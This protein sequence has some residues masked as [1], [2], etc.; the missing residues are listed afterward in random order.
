MYPPRFW[1]MVVLSGAGAGLAGGLLMRLL[2]LIEHLAYR[3]T[4]G[5]FLDGVAAVS[6]GRRVAMLFAAG[7]VAG[8]ASYVLPKLA[9]GTVGLTKAIW[10]RSGQMPV[11]AT[12][13]NSLLSIIIVGMGVSLGREG[14]LKDAGGGI[15]SKLA[16]WFSLPVDQRR[17]LVACAAGGGMAAAYNIPF[18]GALFAVE[19]LM[20]SLSFSLV[21]PAL[22]ASMIATGM[23]W[24]FLPDQPTYVVPVYVLQRPDIV[25]ALLAAPVFGLASILWVRVIGWSERA[26]PKGWHKV[27]APVVVFTLIGIVSIWFPDL[28]G[29]G[30]G[31]VQ[32]AFVNKI[33]FKLLASLLVL[34]FFATGACLSTGAPGGVFTPTMTYGALLGGA[35][36]RVWAMLV[37]NSDVGVFAAIGSAAVLA[38]TTQGPISSIVMILELTH[39]VDA[40]MVPVL[41]ATVGASL[42]AHWTEPRSLYSAPFQASADEIVLPPMTVFE[43][44]RSAEYAVVSAAAPYAIVLQS[45]LGK[46]GHCFVVDDK[47]SLVGEL[48]R[49]HL[50]LDPPHAPFDG[51]VAA[52]LSKPVSALLSSASRTEVKMRLASSDGLP[53]PVID[54]A[55]GMMVGAV[56]RPNSP[57]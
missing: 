44:S 24:L 19:V 29:N 54:G 36:G 30:K 47:G 26:K 1:M 13:L 5:D 28:L 7:I 23:S 57:E 45:L 53:V 33:S 51:T 2:R 17:L 15:A 14:A 52:D 55:T 49:E 50:R 25:W 38:V 32:R 11:L 41:I 10:F 42:T 56:Q 6:P 3:Y 16:D 35:L 22:A 39:H 43:G 18:G 4:T 34:R 21:L 31:L 20:G 37:P 40:I 9:G 8:A 46:K 48:T 12:L 27:L